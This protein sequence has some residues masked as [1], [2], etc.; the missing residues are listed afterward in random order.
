MESTNKRISNMDL[1]NNKYDLDILEKNVKY[2][3]KEFLVTLF[4]S[5][6]F[7]ES[8]E[9]FTSLDHKLWFDPQ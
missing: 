9:N 1:I 2:L 8:S 4:W 3:S 7:A 6:I 5:L